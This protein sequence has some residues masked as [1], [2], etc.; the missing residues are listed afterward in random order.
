[1]IDED[2]L[3]RAAANCA[4]AYRTWAAGVGRPWRAW[5]D[6]VVA[7]MGLPVDL[8]PNHASVL[9]PLTDDAVPGV[10]ERVRS[11]FD[12]SPGGPFELWSAWSTPDLAPFGFEPWSVPMM[13]RPAGGEAPAPPPE[14]EIVEVD[15]E[16]SAAEAS[17]L[18]TVFGTPPDQTAGRITPELAS[19]TFRFWLGRV[20]GEPASMAAASV[21][22][23]YVGLYAVATA[24]AFRGRGYGEALTWTATMFRP[25]LPATLQ[26]SPMGRPVY[27]RMG[28]EVVAAFSNWTIERR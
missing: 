21:S 6:L 9:R 12:G 20:D 15:D 28:Y 1:V 18:L 22:H 8:P 13:N 27:E 26:A 11:F 7:D 4:E 24:P 16:R 10:I 17:A 2:A 19:E 3:A 5:D 14:L 25:D 23:G